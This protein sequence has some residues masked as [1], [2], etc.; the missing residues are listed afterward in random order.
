MTDHPVD[1]RRGHLLTAFVLAAFQPG[2]G[3]GDVLAELHTAYPDMTF[4][5]A[6]PALVEALHVL[7]AGT[8]MVHNAGIDTLR[9]QL[10][11]TYPAADRGRPE[12]TDQ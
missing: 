10:A 1:L 12:G 3:E 7:G 5:E 11:Q 2:A 4:L 9:E 6:V 8:P